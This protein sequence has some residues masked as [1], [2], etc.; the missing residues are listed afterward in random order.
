MHPLILWLVVSHAN[1][2]S[3]LRQEAFWRQAALD[4][5][6]PLVAAVLGGLAVT[7]ICSQVQARREEQV[8]REELLQFD[9]RQEED[10]LRE[11]S[12]RRNQISLDIMRIAFGFYTRLIEPTRVEQ[13]EGRHQVTLG[14]LPKHYEEFRITARVLEEQLRVYFPDGEARWLWH[15]VVDMLSVRYYRLVHKGPRLDDMIGTHGDHPIDKKIP[16]FIRPFFLGP[17]DLQWDDREEFHNTVMQRYEELLTK[18]INLVVHDDINWDGDPVVL[19]P[20]RGPRLK[21]PA[22]RGDIGSRSTA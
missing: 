19:E 5:V 15:G 3:F 14:D 4:A 13:Y 22:D 10:R 16:Q 6:S 18:L 12:E 9:L 7:L 2:W 8:R 21:V 1:A 20:G 17:N 11:E